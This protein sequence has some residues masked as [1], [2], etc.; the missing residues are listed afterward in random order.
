[1]DV[2]GANQSRLADVEPREKVEELHRNA[3]RHARF[4]VQYAV[5]CGTELLIQKEKLGH[6]KFGPWLLTLSFSE[7]QAQRYMQGALIVA[8]NPTR[9]S[10]VESLRELL[11]SDK[12]PAPRATPTPLRIVPPP[13]PMQ[14]TVRAPEDRV[15]EV[16]ARL[17]REEPPT[18][19]TVATVMPLAVVAPHIESVPSGPITVAEVL[20]AL[21]PHLDELEAHGR[22]SQDRISPSSVATEAMVIR[23]KLQ[24][25]AMEDRAA[26]PN[27]A[28]HGGWLFDKLVQKGVEARL[29]EMGV[30]PDDVRSSHHR[31]H[32]GTILKP[33]PIVVC[34]ET[35]FPSKTSRLTYARAYTW[36]QHC[37]EVL[38]TMP[39]DSSART[40]GMHIAHLGKK[41]ARE[42]QD[43]GA[44]IN[45]I[46]VGI[47][48][49]GGDPKDRDRWIDM[50]G[51]HHRIAKEGRR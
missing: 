3:D 47:Q 46:G 15:I 20:G 27:I 49:R 19:M 12:P 44:F 24:L 9:V 7:R 30:I 11:E 34:G 33:E 40:I 25:L 22:Q 51:F 8:A 48:A 10:E 50:E 6:G 39:R 41:I 26:L 32:D 36:A 21:G 43:I 2:V 29:K 31:L 18:A 35:V 23:R 17:V 16:E 38:T 45:T 13:A 4:A 1:M 14:V 42:H 28:K 5:A 37:H